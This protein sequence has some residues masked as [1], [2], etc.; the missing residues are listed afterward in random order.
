[1]AE[2]IVLKE[3]HGAGVLDWVSFGYVAYVETAVLYNV[4]QDFFLG[5][6]R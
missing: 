1:M 3:P 4:L 6:N 2:I 5:R